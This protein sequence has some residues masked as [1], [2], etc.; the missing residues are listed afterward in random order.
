MAKKTIIVK[1][2]LDTRHAALFVQTA[3]KFKS[4]VKIAVDD[5]IVNAKSL[6][7]IISLGLSEG[8]EATISA[9]GEDAEVAVNE[10][11]SVI[12]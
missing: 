11:S 1:K 4:N 10:V 3:S 6:M 2:S 12:G 5:K 7:C 8:I 9:E